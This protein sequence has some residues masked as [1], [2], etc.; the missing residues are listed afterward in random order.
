VKRLIDLPAEDALL[1]RSHELIRAIG[2]TA[3]SEARLRQVRR[4]LD[5][6]GARRPRTFWLRA[7]I[8]LALIGSGAS[9][10]ALSGAFGNG[11]SP[12]L[13]PRLEVSP[14]S[15]PAQRAPRAWPAVPPAASNSPSAVEAPPRISSGA[16][17]VVPHVAASAGASDVARVHEAARAL[18]G[19]GDAERALRILEASGE[20][21]GPLAEEA[22]ALRIEAAS[23]RGDARAVT[24]ARSY[25]ARYPAGRYRELAERALAS[26]KP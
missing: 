5:E 13:A 26:R 25:L 14:S 22:L 10:L 23:A 15:E 24:L 20:V 7:A 12:K 2:P 17:R 11:V 6:P 21:R 9:A 3:L 19:E 4:R 16:R 1:A 18:R 8:A